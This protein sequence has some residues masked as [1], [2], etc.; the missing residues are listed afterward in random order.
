MSIKLQ[1]SCFFFRERL[2]FLLS[3]LFGIWI[4][5]WKF[6]TPLNAFKQ[7]FAESTHKHPNNIKRLKKIRSPNE[8]NENGSLSLSTD[9]RP[10]QL[11]FFFLFFFLFSVGKLPYQLSFMTT[12]NNSE[13]HSDN[14][15]LS[16][17]FSPHFLSFLLCHLSSTKL[18][19]IGIRFLF[20]SSLANYFDF[21]SHCFGLRCVRYICESTKKM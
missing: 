14:R 6:Y 4:L 9:N 20:N 1:D 19:L 18:N 2:A 7:I 13:S 11:S 8:G 10:Y 21:P 3:F 12:C 15:N 5:V 17:S 16:L